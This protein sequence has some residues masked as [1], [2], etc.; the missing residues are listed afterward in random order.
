MQQLLLLLLL[1]SAC[2]ADL[3]VRGGGLDV[4]KGE[5]EGVARGGWGGRKGGGV[6]CYI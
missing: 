4:P 5:G 6:V 3:S 2:L 1:K